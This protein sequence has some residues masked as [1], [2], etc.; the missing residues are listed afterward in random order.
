MLSRAFCCTPG[1]ASIRTRALV[2]H[3][4]LSTTSVTTTHHAD[5]VDDEAL[6]SELHQTDSTNNNNTRNPI[7]AA[8]IREGL[9]LLQETAAKIQASSVTR[10][11]LDIKKAQE[12]QVA[13][14]D[15]SPQRQ[16]MQ[17]HIRVAALDCLEA[18]ILRQQQQHIEDAQ[19]EPLGDWSVQGEPIEI[20]AIRLS[21]S[22][23]HAVLYW[24]LPRSL[25]ETA[26]LDQV[27]KLQGVL[28]AQWKAQSL[29][30]A[31]RAKLLQR[32]PRTPD[33][34]LEPATPDM[35][36]QVVGGVVV[37]ADDDEEDDEE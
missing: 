8:A 10:E 27:L 18:H 14:E 36:Q 37:D 31:T 12:Q 32:W 22:L 5:A 29:L 25:V 20:V 4:T 19:E 21:P 3:K 24:T 33:L 15:E 6:S 11:L 2:L 16:Y 1:V 7:L 23:Q 34:R 35:I 30:R 13:E 9:P 17:Y 26:H 28:A